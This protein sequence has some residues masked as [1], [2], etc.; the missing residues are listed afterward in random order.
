MAITRL[1]GANAI[2][3][4][5]PAANVAT[6]TFSNFPTDS[7]IQTKHYFISN[8]DTSTTSTSFVDIGSAFNFTPLST[9]SILIIHITTDTKFQGGSIGQKIRLLKDGTA[10]DPIGSNDAWLQYRDDAGTSN[11][12]S[13][14]AFFTKIANSSTSQIAFKLQQATFDDNTVAVGNWGNTEVVIQEIKE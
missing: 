7:V 11:N 6:L 9:N 4:T 12:H 2:S 8:S 14:T 5:I 13:S 3:G 1:G 10:L